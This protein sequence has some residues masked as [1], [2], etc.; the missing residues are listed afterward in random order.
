[1]PTEPKFERELH[2]DTVDPRPAPRPAAV[3]HKGAWVTLEPVHLGHHAAGLFAA[4]NKGEGTSEI[5]EYL[6][7]GPFA[8]SESFSDW[9]AG[10]TGS[11]DPLFFTLRDLEHD[12]VAGMMSY[13]SIVPAN[14]SIEIGHIWFAPFLQKTRAATEAIF[15]SLRHAFDDLGYRR[16]EWKCNAMNKGSRAAAL[17]FG[18]RHEGIFYRN[19][20]TKGRNRDTAWYSIID[21]EWPAVRAGFE[22]WLEPANFDANGNQKAGLGGLIERERNL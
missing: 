20:I 16:M 18:F 1:M 7:Y 13:L 4:G 21:E 2:R 6:P 8:D 10:C 5:W 17:R 3:P 14:R 12:R 19:V 11:A 15:L 9:F 22:A